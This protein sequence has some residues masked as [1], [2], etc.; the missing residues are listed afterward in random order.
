[1]AMLVAGACLLWAPDASAACAAAVVVDGRVLLGHAVDH[2]SRL[3]PRAGELEATVPACDDSGDSG[4]EGQETT[5][6]GL[7]GVPAQVAVVDRAGDTLYVDAA[8]LPALRGH[9]VHAVLYG[10]RGAPELRRCRPSATDVRGRV[11]LDG[12]LRIRTAKRT[13]TLRVDGATRFAN[14]PAYAPVREGQRLRVATS[15]CGSRR[16]AD[17]VTFVGA[18]PAPGTGGP[19]ADA[20]GGGLDLAGWQVVLV[21]LFG[22][23][24]ALMAV[25]WRRLGR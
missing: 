24:V 19:G 14:R 20:D 3:P 12:S 18:A 15:R 5:V 7:R 10:S 1:M 13:V 6:V 25:I 23:A 16:V 11:V 17:R 9:P 4:G 8:S 22:A 21:L 2:P